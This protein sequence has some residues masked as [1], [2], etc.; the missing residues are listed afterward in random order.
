MWPLVAN[1]HIESKYDGGDVY[2]QRTIAPYHS[3]YAL[4]L[5]AAPLCPAAWDAPLRQRGASLY[6]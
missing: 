3:R 5:P 2:I 4:T 6:Y 1:N